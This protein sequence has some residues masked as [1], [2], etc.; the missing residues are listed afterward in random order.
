MKRTPTYL[1]VVLT[2]ACTMHCS[3]CH[4]EGLKLPVGPFEYEAA[5]G[6][7]PAP[8]NLGQA[9]MPRP[10][11][12]MLELDL[13]KAQLEVALKQG[14]QKLKFLG[15][16][17]LV[18]PLLVPLIHW[19]K[20]QAPELDVSLITAGGVPPER[21]EQAFQAGLDRANLSIHG[22]G[23]EAF[24]RHSRAQNREGLYAWRMENL[25]RLLEKG[26]FLKLNY[27]YTGP[28]VEN[29]LLE[30]LTWASN[31]PVVVSVLDDLNQHDMSPDTIRG[32]L[33]R[34]LGVPQRV[35]RD[36]D[37]H[38]LETERLCWASGLVVEIKS[39]QL[40][41]L[42]PWSACVTC[43][44]RSVCREGI[45]ALRLEP[46]GHLRP[47]ADRPDLGYSLLDAVQQGT[48]HAIEQWQYQLSILQHEGIAV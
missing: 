26:R 5:Y 1:R 25:N 31:K 29:D 44:R 8:L 40:G 7:V 32:M 22:W 38:S 20:E 43:P 28:E 42:A 16:E 17:P 4:A 19:V 18:S 36:D 3:F 37:P 13:W 23:R 27:V 48:R 2:E 15:G 33:S 9:G 45:F 6:V 10:S 11:R 12:S 21:L 47:C 14:I 46:D 35:L 30:L 41:Q 39:S 34:L 24:A